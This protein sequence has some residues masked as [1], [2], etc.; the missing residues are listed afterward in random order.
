MTGKGWVVSVIILVLIFGGLATF[1]RAFLASGNLKLNPGTT[2]QT[3]GESKA[4]IAVSPSPTAAPKIMTK[5][6]AST[7]PSS[8]VSS[9]Q[10]PPI[11]KPSPGKQSYTIAIFGDSMADTMGENLDYL[12]K[13]MMAR[14][15][16]TKFKFYNYGIGSQNVIEAS[17]RFSDPFSY[18]TR[19]YPPIDEISADII[20]ISTFAYNPLYPY[21]LN[22]YLAALKDV[23]NKA[24][25]SGAEV[26]LLAEIA[27]LKEGFGKGAGGV[28]WDEAKTKEHVGYILQNLD[29]ALDLA[30]QTKTPLINAYKKSQVDGK[31]GNRTYVGIH[32]G[33][34]PSIE[35]EIFMAELIA[36]SL[37]LQ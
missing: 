32:D 20:I 34:H 2:Q 22:A 15:P 7:I 14:Y 23:I 6:K 27:P 25:S 36:Q 5:K 8:S 11:T 37:K 29:S 18:Q 3:L 24:K 10:P 4:I 26:Y 16:A 35:G 1:F 17:K 33:I 19:N 9:P 28:N 12:D 30:S 13:S 31:Y 21:D